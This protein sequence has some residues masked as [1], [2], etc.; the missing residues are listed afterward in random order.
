MVSLHNQT[1]KQWSTS[2]ASE[3]SVF[4]KDKYIDRQ[5]M[6]IVAMQRSR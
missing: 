5:I 1:E 6:A 2:V 3:A 4:A